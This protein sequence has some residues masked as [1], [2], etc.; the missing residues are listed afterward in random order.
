MLGECNIS[1]TKELF[2]LR[3]VLKKESLVSPVLFMQIKMYKKLYYNDIKKVIINA[4]I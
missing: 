2:I 4:L 1:G 3:L